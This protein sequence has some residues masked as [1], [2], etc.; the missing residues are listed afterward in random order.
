MASGS[1]TL[2]FTSGQLPHGA[3]ATVISPRRA[4][5]ISSC[6]VC[7][8][9]PTTGG[10]AYLHEVQNCSVTSS[11]ITRS[12]WFEQLKP[13]VPGDL[14]LQVFMITPAKEFRHPIR[15]RQDAGLLP[16]ASAYMVPR[17][18]QMTQTLT[19]PETDSLRCLEKRLLVFC[20]A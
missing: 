11:T 19:K 12:S 2:C 20:N 6:S 7:A 15:T 9:N 3:A 10:V 17:G 8:K 5:C 13:N 4:F 1:G 16:H 14:Y 18:I